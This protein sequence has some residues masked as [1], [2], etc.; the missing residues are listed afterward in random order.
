MIKLLNFVLSNAT[1]VDLTTVSLEVFSSIFSVILFLFSS[2][3]VI[4]FAWSWI[5][6]SEAAADPCP[7]YIQN[8]AIATEVAP[9][10]AFLI[11]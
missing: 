4:W 10:L 9:K 5:L 11:E 7:K 1:T 2:T 8:A 6:V 3:E